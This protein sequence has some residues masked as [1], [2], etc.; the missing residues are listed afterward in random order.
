MEDAAPER[1]K[2]TEH[3]LR[4]IFGLEDVAATAIRS[5]AEKAGLPPHRRL[6]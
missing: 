6:E 3:Y 1:W 4:D 5:P 2:Y